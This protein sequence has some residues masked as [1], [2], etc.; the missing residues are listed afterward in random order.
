MNCDST[1]RY[2]LKLC[3]SIDHNQDCTQLEHMGHY[4]DMDRVQRTEHRAQSAERRA[5]GAG[6]RAQ[7]TWH[8]AQGTG[9]RVQSIETDSETQ[10]PRL[11]AKL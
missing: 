3:R 11:N 2:D 5:Q 8:R 10:G 4:R 7:G 9:H 1:S 6:R